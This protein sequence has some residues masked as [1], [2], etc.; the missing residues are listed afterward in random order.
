MQI[1]NNTRGSVS[2]AATAQRREVI[3]SLLCE[4]PGVGR[5][6]RAERKRVVKLERQDSCCWLLTQSSKTYTLSQSLTHTHTG[7]QNAIKNIAA[8]QCKCTRKIN[9]C[10]I[11]VKAL[12]VCM[13]IRVCI[14][15]SCDA[16]K[17]NV[18]VFVICMTAC[19]CA[20]AWGHL[21]QTYLS[22]QTFHKL[23]QRLK[24]SIYNRKQFISFNSP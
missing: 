24:F 20:C 14:S 23:D 1:P 12:S 6:L 8:S 13:C 4:L 3:N 17:N 21:P 7:S 9:I 18:V 10:I 15:S 2:N 11:W 5:V 16:K 22:L 19:V